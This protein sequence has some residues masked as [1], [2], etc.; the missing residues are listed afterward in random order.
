MA[1][2][3]EVAEQARNQIVQILDYVE[4]ATDSYE[5]S[6]LV[7]QLAH[8]YNLGIRTNPRPAQSTVRL[9]AVQAATRKMP[10][11]VRMETK[12]DGGRSYNALVVEEVRTFSD[13]EESRLRR[14]EEKYSTEEG[15]TEEERQEAERLVQKKH[16]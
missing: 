8:L 14:I 9:R 10:V 4:T 15:A 16:G 6:A 3:L 11:T 12:E 13:E 7:K 5:R 1:K 2:Y